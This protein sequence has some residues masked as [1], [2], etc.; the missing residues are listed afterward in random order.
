MI[1]SEGGPCLLLG[2]IFG[3]VSEKIEHHI[4]AIAMVYALNMAPAVRTKQNR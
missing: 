4:I 3:G 1:C 2:G